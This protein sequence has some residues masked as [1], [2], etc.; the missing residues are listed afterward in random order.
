MYS[1]FLTSKISLQF[2]RGRPH[3]GQQIQVRFMKA[4]VFDPATVTPYRRKFVH[5]CRNDPRCVDDGERAERHWA[6]AST[7]FDGRQF[8][9][10]A[11]HPS[12]VAFSLRRR[13][14]NTPLTAVDGVI[15]NAMLKYSNARF[16]DRPVILHLF[17]RGRLPSTACYGRRR[18]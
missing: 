8:V 7:M 1:S 13:R 5:I 10:N 9:Y 3:R 16:L 12:K 15:Q 6:V 4:E 2:Q 14:R 11:A 17:D 18:L